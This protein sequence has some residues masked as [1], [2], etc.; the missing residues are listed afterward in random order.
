VIKRVFGT[1]ISVRAKTRQ[2]LG[3][4][5]RGTLNIRIRKNIDGNEPCQRS[6]VNE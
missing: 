5:H 3:W 1:A 6:K 4:S 2:V